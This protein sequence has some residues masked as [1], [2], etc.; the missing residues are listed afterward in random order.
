MTDQLAFEVSN[1]DA[2]TVS[3]RKELGA[4]ETLCAQDCRL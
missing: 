4:Y 1:F 2:R 3:P